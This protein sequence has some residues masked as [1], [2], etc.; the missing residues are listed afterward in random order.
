MR[1]AD[2]TPGGAMRTIGGWRTQTLQVAE[3]RGGTLA[4]LDPADNLIDA[5]VSPWPPPEIVQ[6]LYASRH[7][8]AFAGGDRA[9]V[10]RALGFYTDLQS[11]HSEDALTW[12]VFGPILYA[13]PAIRERF[14]ADLLALLDVRLEGLEGVQ[15]WLWRRLPHP[16]TLVPG[17][18]EI[19]FGIQVGDVVLLGEA[20]WLSAVGRGQGKGEDKD[21]IDLRREFCQ[22]YAPVIFPSARRYIVLGL[23]LRNDVLEPEDLEV[24][25]RVL[26]LRELT[27]E[28]VCGLDSHP[29]RAELREYLLWKKAHSSGV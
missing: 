9:A 15:L 3:S 25:S 29:A 5:E 26:A 13:E 22:K 28:S 1:N 20:K 4:V 11:V 12:N 8:R 10:T 23:S 17:G 19:D 16:D 6:K 21:Q 24:G 7:V 14:I 2:P 18:P 27:W